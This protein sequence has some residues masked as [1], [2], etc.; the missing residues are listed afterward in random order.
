MRPWTRVHGW[1]GGRPQ[2]GGVLTGTYPEN[3]GHYLVTTGAWAAETVELLGCRLPVHP[4]RGQIVLFRPLAPVLTNVLMVGKRYLVPR[5]DGRVLVGSTEEPEAGFEK[6]NTPEA[7]RG[8]IDFA[9]E[10]VPALRDAE[11][12]ATWAGLRPGSPDGMPFIGPVPGYSNVTAAVG[13]LRAGVQLSI[14]T[15]ELVRDLLIGRSTAVPADAF[16]LDREPNPITR[17]AFRS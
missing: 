6:A 9:A 17:P 7:V 16:R 11:V 4:V 10:L 15:A 12:E 5:A 2:A 3:A 8:L 13:H 1:N 14:G